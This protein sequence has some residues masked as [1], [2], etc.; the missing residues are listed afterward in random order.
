MGGGNG[1]SPAVALV[2]SGAT[3]FMVVADLFNAQMAVHAPSAPFH[4]HHTLENVLNGELRFPVKFLD[5]FTAVGIR[6][7]SDSIQCSSRL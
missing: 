4:V 2:A 1:S 6:V 5:E 7:E 3:E